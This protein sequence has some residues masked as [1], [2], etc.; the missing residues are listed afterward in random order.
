M[1][2]YNVEIRNI[3]A[4]IA[5]MQI[6]QDETRTVTVQAE[7]VHDAIGQAVRKMFDGCGLGNM[8]PYGNDSHIGEITTGLNLY[9]R[10]RVT[11]TPA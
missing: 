10:I 8:E 5:K 7:H 11:V 3:N 2:T 4:R 9:G 1:Q 6:A